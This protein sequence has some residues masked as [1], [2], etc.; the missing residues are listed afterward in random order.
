LLSRI[1]QVNAD[2]DDLLHKQQNWLTPLANG[3]D[4]YT[5]FYH[6]THSLAKNIVCAS[7]GIIGHDVASFQSVPVTDTI[8]H[9]LSIASDVYIPFHFFCGVP[10]LDEH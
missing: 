7:C 6:T 3:S 8:L 10:M 9:H 1:P 5:D 4:L 2:F